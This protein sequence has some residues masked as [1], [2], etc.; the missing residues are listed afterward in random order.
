[1]MDILNVIKGD[2]VQICLSAAGKVPAIFKDPNWEQDTFV[3][4]PLRA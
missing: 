4:M 1:M 3:V 2:S